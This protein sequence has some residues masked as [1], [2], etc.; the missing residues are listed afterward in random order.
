MNLDD[1]KG[2]VGRAKSSKA[3]DNDGLHRR[4]G[5]WH[6][7]LKDGG[8]W[9]EFSTHAT[10]YNEARKAR[11][12]KLQEFEAGHMPTDFARW[13]IQRAATLWKESRSKELEAGTISPQTCSTEKYLL[14]SLTKA[15]GDRRLGD[16][17]LDDIEAYRSIRMAKVRPR[18]IN[19]EIKMLRMILRKARL[20]ARLADGYKPLPENK[21]GPGCA[22]RPEEEKRLFDVASSNPLWQTAYSAAVLAAHTTARSRE[23]KG[24]RLGD[25]NLMEGTITIR[26]ST[27]KTDAGCRV[28]PLDSA[29]TRAVVR[30]LERA[31]LLGATE[32]THYLF[33][34]CRFRQTKQNSPTTAMGYDP[35][36]PMTSWRSAWRSLRGTAGLPKLRFHDLRHHCITRL[37]ESGVP[38][39]VIMSIAGHVSKEM[40]EHYSHIR[41][42]AKR[43]AVAKLDQYHERDSLIQ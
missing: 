43:Q 2:Q 12:R 16:L 13:T 28:I 21:R 38:D 22:L 31:R 27:T 8:R 26:R 33:P 25:I 40:L 35:T 18:T 14:K 36:K 15:L 19:L 5:I 6:F 3:R 34:F 10:N 24:L 20:W 42:E 23:L 7:K 4:R 30:Q 17:T 29:A 37:A 39:H 32:P 11:Q 41:I 9:R 1:S